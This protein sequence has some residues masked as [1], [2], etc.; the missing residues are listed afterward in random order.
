M[1]FLLTS[2]HVKNLSKN[3]LV[4]LAGSN[5]FGNLP[6]FVSIIFFST[7]IV[8]VSPTVIRLIR[9][10]NCRHHK[11]LALQVSAFLSKLPFFWFFTFSTK[12]FNL[13]MQVPTAEIHTYGSSL[14]SIRLLTSNQAFNVL[15]P[16]ST[17]SKMI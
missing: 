15:I 14:N 6:S 11:N 4:K 16:Y 5:S 7:V 8:C 2:P 10:D 1:T 12:G 17:K 13:S 3:K 9:N